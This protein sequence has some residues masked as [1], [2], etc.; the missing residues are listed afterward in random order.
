MSRLERTLRGLKRRLDQQRTHRSTRRYS[1]AW[2]ADP[3]ADEPADPTNRESSSARLRRDRTTVIPWLDRTRPLAGAKL[4]EVG[5]GAGISTVALAERGARVTG[6]DLSDTHLAAARDALLRSGLHADLVAGNAAHLDQLFQAGDFDWI[7]FWAA[8]EH[9]TVD[10]RLAAIAAAWALLPTGGLLSVV[11]TPNR[12]WYQDSHTSYLPFYMWLPDELA[13]R[14]ARNS[15]RQGFGDRY[16]ELN[17]DELLHFQRRG[18][19]VSVHEFDAALGGLDGLEVTSCMQIEGRAASLLRRA[20]WRVSQGGRYERLL[21]GV[22]ADIHPGFL[23][24]FL[25]LTMRKR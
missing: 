16:A 25:Y 11:E 15:P 13:L 23:Q 18:R 17:A 21:Q 2:V 6:L 22:A 12:L 10:E 4:L 24:P 14:L 3:W 1:A 9:M 20:G 7:V 8:L 19:G 5:C